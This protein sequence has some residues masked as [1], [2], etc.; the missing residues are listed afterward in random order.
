MKICRMA[1][2]LATTAVLGGCARPGQNISES[3]PAVDLAQEAAAIRTTDAQWLAAVQ[4]R[5]AEKTASFWSQDGVLFVPGAAPIRGRKAILDY[6]AQSFKDPDF[7]ITWTG[8]SI[9][10]DAGGAMAYETA[11]NRVTY[12][13]GN[14]VVTA[15]NNG[16]VVWRKQPDGSWKAAIDIGTPAPPAQGQ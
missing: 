10:V 9:I 5:D 13:Q 16:V 14:K 7:S 6:V 2:L 4:A 12:R 11:S 3:R 1:L 15:R 8:D